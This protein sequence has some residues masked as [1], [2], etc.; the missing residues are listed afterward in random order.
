VRL[1]TDCAYLASHSAEEGGKEKEAALYQGSS[2]VYRS[3]L[4]ALPSPI[5]PPLWGKNFG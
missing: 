5:G 2:L 4:G 1:L 3:R